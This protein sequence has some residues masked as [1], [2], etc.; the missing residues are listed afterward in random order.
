MKMFINKMK[1]VIIILLAGGLPGNI[2][3]QKTPY[4]AGFKVV[5]IVDTS[6]IY[7]SGTDTNDYLHYR[8]IDVDIWYPA[9]TYK[10]DTA[11]K[12]KSFLDLF[13]GRANYYTASNAGDGLTENFAQSFC[14]GFKC[15][16][17]DLLLNYKTDSYKNAAPA[18][19]NFPLIIYMASYNG[20]GY[21]NFRLFENLAKKG[22]VTVSISSIGRYPG[23]MTM[24]NED[25]MEQVYDA[26]S[27]LKS[28]K[29][30]PYL[31][32]NSIAVLSY[33]WGGLS[34]AVLS[35]MVPNVRC[36]ISLDGSEFHHYNKNKD[37]DADFDR[38]KDSPSFKGSVISIPYLRLE[39]SPL[40]KNA[41]QDSIY[42]FK[43]KL[44]SRHLILKIDSSEHQDFCCL[45]LVV[46]ESGNCSNPSF[47]TTISKLTGNFLEDHLKGKHAVSQTNR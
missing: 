7:K 21:E 39:S 5:R 16:T 13:A 15:S 4:T 6:R 38:I 40:I 22:F 26:V 47:Y 34:G 28:L 3:A 20:M 24:K 17:P 37:E 42:N 11:L 33:S 31:D 1:I 43:E 46:K 8:P 44:S 36:L 27:S 45:P 19:G 18:N 14:E 23:D 32:F 2:H 10:T 9:Q 25:M 12:F 29:G 35:M 41:E 30:S